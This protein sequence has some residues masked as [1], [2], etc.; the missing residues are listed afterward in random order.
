MHARNFFSFV[1]LSTTCCCVSSEKVVLIEN[2]PIVGDELEDFYAFRGIPYAEAPVGDFRFAAPKPY[3]TKWN[4]KKEFKNY[5]EVCAQYDHLGY[6]FKGSEDCLTLNVFLPKS[7]ANSVNKVPVIFFIHGGAFMFGSAKFY[8][9]EI[10][11]KAQNMILVTVNYRLGILGFLSTEDEVI[12]GNFGMKDQVEALRWVQ[13]NI[14]VFNGDSDK[15]TIVGYSAGGASVQLHYM[16]PLTDGLFNNGISHSGVAINPW[17]MQENSREKAHQIAAYTNCPEDHQQLLTCLREKPAEDL[18]M[19]AKHFQSFL[20]NP[21]SPFG[22][23]VESPS[24][25]AFLTDHPMD[26]L[27]KGNFKKLPWLLSQT[28]DEGLYPTA[29]FYDEEILRTINDKWNEFAPFILD[30]NGTT[31]DAKTKLEVSKETRLKYLGKLP[32]T[33]KN[34][35]DFNDVSKKNFSQTTIHKIFFHR[36]SQI[37][38]SSMEL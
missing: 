8:L 13:R 31:D 27:E 30:F 24:K 7:V 15:V 35:L 33:K 38:C 22:V 10:I 9:P 20:Y 11:M 5:G 36:L 32:I 6:D 19:L 17:V 16:S 26:L 14:E 2:G 23:V 37:V 4:G 28:Q 18:V 25:T 21:F 1:I 12:P 3:S 29:E 34:F